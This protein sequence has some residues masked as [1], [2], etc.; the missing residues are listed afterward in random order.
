MASSSF[1]SDRR[2]IT[3]PQ[4][5]D[6][7]GAQPRLRM[8]VL[9]ETIAAQL[10]ERKDA[11]EHVDIVFSEPS[12]ERFRQLAPTLKPHLVIVDLKFLGP[13]PVKGM[14]EL[15]QIADI[16]KMMIVYSFA[17][18]E[19]IRR[20]I[21]EKTS[22]LKSPLNLGALRTSII[23]FLAT[24]LWPRR[25]QVDAQ[26]LELESTVKAKTPR[27]FTA[28]QLGRLAEIRSAVDCECPNHLSGI[29][30]SVND[31]EDYSKQCLNK[32]DADARIH[33]MLYNETSKARA[34]LEA[35][36]AELV[37]YEKITV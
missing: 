32:N 3:A 25:K 2:V 7:S 6:E 29:L 1:P 20:L 26:G 34:I 14:D 11:L 17:K 21:T 27:Q 12:L 9:H 31:F 37:K 13:D 28:E 22:I 30:T 19:T 24:Q 15:N 36:L 5:A 33:A 35:A 4:A 8:A 10:R 16:D 23:N 18:S